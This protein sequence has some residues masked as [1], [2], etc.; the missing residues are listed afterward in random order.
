MAP[1]Q[2]EQRVLAERSRL[3]GPSGLHWIPAGGR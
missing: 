2:L 1:F 3:T